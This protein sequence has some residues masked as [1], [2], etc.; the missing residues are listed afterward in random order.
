MAKHP[1][2]LED[3]PFTTGDEV[4]HNGL[5]RQ[6]PGIQA[7]AAADGNPDDGAHPT[8][9]ELPATGYP[10][11][12]QPLTDWFRERYRREPTDRELGVLMAAMNERDAPPPRDGLKPDPEGWRTDVSAPPGSR[13]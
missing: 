3:R 6:Q 5:Q 11:F 13:R 1:A 12:E 10:P 8:S 9:Q 2:N 4:R 7:D